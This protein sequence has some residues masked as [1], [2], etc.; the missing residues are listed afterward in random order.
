MDLLAPQLIP[1]RLALPDRRL[2][3]R[4]AVQCDAS[5]Q[6]ETGNGFV[7]FAE[8]FDPGLAS[9]VHVDVQLQVVPR[10]DEW[11]RDDRAGLVA[12]SQRDEAVESQGRE[13]DG[14]PAVFEIGLFLGRQVLTV[15][16]GAV[17]PQFV[18]EVSGP[19]LRCSRTT[20]RLSRPGG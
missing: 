3:N 15:S 5:S 9:L 11:F 1:A 12:G 16:D 6:F 18:G 13:A 19:W 14:D 2:P 10:D 17:G 7:V 4:V 8:D 20:V